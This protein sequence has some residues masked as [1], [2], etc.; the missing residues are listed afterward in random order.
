MAGS[1]YYYEL[2]VPRGNVANYGGLNGNIYGPP[3]PMPYTNSMQGNYMQAPGCRG[4]V[5]RVANHFP[6]SMFARERDGYLRDRLD[7]DDDEDIEPVNTQKDRPRRNR[8]SKLDDD[9]EEFEPVK[10]PV[11]SRHTRASYLDSDD[12]IA[13]VK[14]TGTA[15]RARYSAA[16]CL[17]DD[18]N[19]E[20]VMKLEDIEE[21][22]RKLREAT[23]SVLNRFATKTNTQPSTRLSRFFSSYLND[24]KDY[25]KRSSSY[26]SDSYSPSYSSSYARPSSIKP[27]DSSSYDPPVYDKRYSMYLSSRS[28]NK[29]SDL[30]KDAAGKSDRGPIPQATAEP[31]SYSRRRTPRASA[32]SDDNSKINS[33]IAVMSKYILSKNK[34]KN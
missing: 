27:V 18:A 28:T 29:D 12:D 6:Q 21:D 33:R 30:E 5:P 3:P 34:T 1:G 17:D 23:S 15:T 32:S 24:D 13:P 26:S 9:D 2:P 14:T 31:E 22:L 4:A 20:P 16:S 11:R 10:I 25:E 7:E 8:A 19:A